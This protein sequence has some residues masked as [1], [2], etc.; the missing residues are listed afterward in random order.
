M[1]RVTMLQQ[2]TGIRESASKVTDLA[3]WCPALTSVAVLTSAEVL[4]SASG[5]DRFPEQQG[6]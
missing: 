4:T 1:A 6:Q 5:Y 2:L 3:A